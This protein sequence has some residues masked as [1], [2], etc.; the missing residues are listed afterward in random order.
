MVPVPA[1]TP[2]TTPVDASTVAMLVAELLHVPPLVPVVDKVML[3]PKQAVLL[4]VIVSARGIGRTPI[5]T[6]LVVEHPEAFVP[7]TE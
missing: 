4:P 5:E 7:V 1:A 3:V 6:V 2:V